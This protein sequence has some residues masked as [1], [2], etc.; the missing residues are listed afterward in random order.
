MFMV[1]FCYFLDLNRPFLLNNFYLFN[2]TVLLTASDYFLFFKKLIVQQWHIL[3]VFLL[4][5]HRWILKK[6][7]KTSIIIRNISWAANQHII[8]I[9]E[10]H[11]TL[12]DWSNDAEYSAL[13]TRTNYSLQYTTENS[14]MFNNI[15]VFMFYIQYLT[16]VS[17][18]LTFL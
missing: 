1:L 10:D 9:S 12:K 3:F 8:M 11:M 14:I 6:L 5:I 7:S 4:F 16:E 17:T 2:W 18:H 13:I 15:I